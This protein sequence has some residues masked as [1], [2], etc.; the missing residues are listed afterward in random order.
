MENAGLENDEQ[1][2]STA[3]KDAVGH[4]P[5]VVRIFIAD[6]AGVTSRATESV[7][8]NRPLVNVTACVIALGAWCCAA[9][10]RTGRSE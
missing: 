5:A 6:S 7:G 3:G 1:N 4:F 9:D 2:R 10:R 8:A